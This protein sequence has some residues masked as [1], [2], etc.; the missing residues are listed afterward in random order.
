MEILYFF[1]ASSLTGLIGLNLIFRNGILAYKLLGIYLCLFCLLIFTSYFSPHERLKD[2]PEIVLIQSSAHFLFGP[3]H[4]L[5]VYFTLNPNNKFSN[6]FWLLFIPFVLHLAELLAFYIGPIYVKIIEVKLFFSNKS[7]A[8]YPNSIFHIPAFTMS[9]I[10]VALT[11]IYQVISLWL[12]FKFIQ[13]KKRIKLK[14]KFLLNWLFLVNV[15]GIFSAFLSI[16][17]L[18]GIISFNNF[19]FSYFDLLMILPTFFNLA[20]L[21]MKPQILKINNFQR[22]VFNLQECRQMGNS[23]FVSG[24]NNQFDSITHQ[25]EAFFILKKPYLDSNL[26]LGVIAIELNVSSR[27]LSQAIQYKYETTYSNFINSWRLNYITEQRALHEEWSNYSFDLLA[28]ISGFSSRQSF[29]N[30]VK[31]IHGTTPTKFLK[32]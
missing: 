2:Y 30:A 13:V 6:Y 3:I 14:N 20:I 26:R 23:S 17:Y 12:V 10:K 25:L 31:K 32:S 1:F 19:P 24:C 16:F 8:N 21:I 4:F 27:V 9:C 5:F 15:L 28:E 29:Y 11:V 22:L 7:L 18:T